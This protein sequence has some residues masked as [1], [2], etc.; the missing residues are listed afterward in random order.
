MTIDKH[1]TSLELSK[2]L[3]ELRVSQQSLFYW[4][5]ITYNEGVAIPAKVLYNP[6]V[7]HENAVT[8][9]EYYSAFVASEIGNLIGKYNNEWAQGWHDS[10]D[11][12]CFHWGNRGSGSMIDGIGQSA[13]SDKKEEA[14]ARAELLIHLIA[15]QKYPL[16]NTADGMGG[17]FLHTEDE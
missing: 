15:P 9:Y 3:K 16:I 4:R 8:I 17:K 13:F 2:R 1:V 14:D 11:L 7:F 5:D 12:W 6:F 10:Y